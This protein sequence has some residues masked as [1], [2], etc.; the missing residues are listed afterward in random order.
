MGTSGNEVRLGSNE[1]TEVELS[2]GGLLTPFL[3]L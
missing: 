3:V 1:W 2:T